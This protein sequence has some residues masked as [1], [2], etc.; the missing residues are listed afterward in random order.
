MSV[1][2]T[3]MRRIRRLPNEVLKC[4]APQSDNLAESGIVD[5]A[6]FEFPKSDDGFPGGSAV[7]GAGYFLMYLLYCH[8]NSSVYEVAK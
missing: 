7:P 8:S 1:I 2:L 6:L 3:M 5:C 4:F